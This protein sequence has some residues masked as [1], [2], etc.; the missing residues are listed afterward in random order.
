MAPG[1]I[2]SAGP[3]RSTERRIDLLDD[4]APPPPY[5]PQD[6]YSTSPG[7]QTPSLND[8]T[9]L[10]GSASCSRA[11]Q[12]FPDEKGR[13]RSHAEVS[14]VSGAPYFAMR[15][16]PRRPQK[17][18]I[19]RVPLLWKAK[20]DKIPLPGRKGIW[21]CRDVN[22]YDWESF[23]TH[24]V[25]DPR[26]ESS[27]KSVPTDQARIA[28][29]EEA[30]RRSRFNSVTHE[31][32]EGFFLPRGLKIFI[33]ILPFPVH[34][35]FADDQ[36]IKKPPEETERQVSVDE[37]LG[38]ALHSAVAKGD[39]SLVETLLNSNAQ[40]NERPSGAAPALYKAVGDFEASVA[41]LGAC[42]AI[43]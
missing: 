35:S 28:S 14:F 26:G 34:T 16:P 2:K 5:T 6:P 30:T 11:S 43:R 23:L 4:F 41:V 42:T 17:A 19:F 20:I 18:V 10:L 1:N 40:A 3:P 32:N 15:P 21:Q 8:E 36:L 25:L 22:Q 39:R 31:W 24:L 13:R 38:L 37:S 7:E 27:S 33:E 9:L 29:E 12:G